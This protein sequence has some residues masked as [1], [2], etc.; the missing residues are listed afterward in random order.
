MIK[1]KLA[2]LTAAC[3]LL[4]SGCSI[5]GE[6]ESVQEDGSAGEVTHSGGAGYVD[7]T[8][9]IRL[10][11]A[12]E[13]YLGGSDE[14]TVRA[15]KRV[16]SAM[17]D[18]KPSA[19]LSDC[20]ITSETA[21]AIITLMVSAVPEFC[22]VDEAYSYVLDGDENVIRLNLNYSADKQKSDEMEAKLL[23][24]AQSIVDETAGMTDYEKTKL[25]H[26]RL[27]LGCSY[28]EHGLNCYT[29][30]GCLVEGRAVCEG[31]S[32][33]FML[34]CELADI[35][36]LV[37]L[38]KTEGDVETL[39]MWNKIKLG[40]EWYNVDITWDDPITNTDTEYVRYDYFNICDAAVLEDHT[41]TDKGLMR[42]P[43]ANGCAFN[44]FAAEGLFVSERDQAETV[45]EDAIVRAADEGKPAAEIK[46][47]DHELFRDVY[48]SFF[49]GD[50]PKAFEILGLAK[51]RTNA[52][53]NT[54]SYLVLKNDPQNTIVIIMDD[55]SQA[56]TVNNE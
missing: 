32:K 44:Y 18:C 8:D 54:D 24:T 46:L 40:D 28:D 34:L 51:Q 53:F 22:S 4:L 13:Y 50:D 38:G 1:K 7:D 6:T 36:C 39:H 16:Y 29:A 26:D 20:S 52:S 14:N 41:F 55:Y 33:A 49:E 47:S 5:P 30:Y 9:S 25:F 48:S 31:Y 27:V 2:A 35:D 11:F 19:D 3:A 43:A 23:E 10:P 17:R 42:S 15:C 21:D 45:L 12:A 56:E 37:V